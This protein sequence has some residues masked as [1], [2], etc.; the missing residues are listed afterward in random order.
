[1][2]KSALDQEGSN[3][4]LNMPTLVG[5]NP[6]GEIPVAENHL[7][8]G[9][10]GR[11]VFSQIRKQTEYSQRQW[12]IAAPLSDVCETEHLGQHKGGLQKEIWAEFKVTGSPNLDLTMGLASKV[13]EKLSP[14]LVTKNPITTIALF[15]ASSPSFPANNSSTTLTETNS[16]SK[17]HDC[18][19]HYDVSLDF[20]FSYLTRRGKVGWNVDHH[21]PWKSNSILNQR[22]GKHIPRQGPLITERLGTSEFS[23][24]FVQL[25]D[26]SGD[27]FAFRV[28]NACNECRDFNELNQSVWVS[29]GSWLNFN[30]PD[31]PVSSLKNRDCKHEPV[32]DFH[33]NPAI[34]SVTVSLKLKVYL[35]IYININLILLWSRKKTGSWKK[36]TVMMRTS[37]YGL[38]R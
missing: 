21:K 24:I 18:G 2:K 20:G 3:Q 26:I 8:T 1:M 4:M 17:Q 7:E 12:E 37:S 10:T 28:S 38:R 6:N 15:N 5:T 29:N 13:K 25:I 9:A 23:D 22:K 33:S 36:K 30:H 14:H 16:N 35:M 11:C 19:N 34:T 31:S 32:V 27:L